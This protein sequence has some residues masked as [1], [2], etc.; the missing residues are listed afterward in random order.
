MNLTINIGEIQTTP[1]VASMEVIKEFQAELAKFPQIECPTDHCFAGGIYR[2]TVIM[3]ADS[4]VVSRHHKTHHFAVIMRG[5]V[6]VWN[7]G[8]VEQ[9]FQGPCMFVTPAGTKRVLHVI[10]ETE[11]STYHSTPHTNVA[12][13]ESDIIEPETP[14]LGDN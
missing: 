7:N 1:K 13:V 14:L 6:D 5:V 12:D 3:P 11:W 4:W 10:E 2:R 9:R 8:K